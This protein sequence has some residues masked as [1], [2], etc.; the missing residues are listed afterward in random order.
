MSDQLLKIFVIVSSIWCCTLIA[1]VPVAESDAL[2][3]LYNNT[4]GANWAENTNWT[5]GDPCTN[6]WFGVTCNGGNTSVEILELLFN[7]LVG[8]LPSALGDLSNLK[9]LNLLANQLTGGI[10][11]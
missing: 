3:A 4:D 10:P 1:D 8:T 9:E 11:A 7:N 6:S 5:V 2:L